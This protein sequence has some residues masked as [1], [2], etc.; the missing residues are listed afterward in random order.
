MIHSLT[1]S[2][3]DRKEVKVHTTVTSVSSS[4]DLLH[5]A[6]RHIRHLSSQAVNCHGDKS[7]LTFH[8][9]SICTVS[10]Q[11]NTQDGKPRRLTSVDLA[12]SQ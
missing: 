3:S 1:E 6:E 5:T 7:L 11:L 4:V 10:H 8:M 12:A 2:L 9:A